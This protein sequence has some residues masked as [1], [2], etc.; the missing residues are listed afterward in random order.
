M[1]KSITTRN[2]FDFLGT[3]PAGVQT[4]DVSLGP[5]LL[6]MPCSTK[7]SSNSCAWA[8]ICIGIVLG[9]N[10]YRDGSSLLERACLNLIFIG[11]HFK[12]LDGLRDLLNNS[13]C[14][15]MNFCLYGLFLL[16]NS[17]S[18]ALGSASMP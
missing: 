2:F 5:S 15:L 11:G 1:G 13:L 9:L 18:F 12:Y 17:S 4:S 7:L 8:L 16:I 3:N 10:L 14:S 6:I